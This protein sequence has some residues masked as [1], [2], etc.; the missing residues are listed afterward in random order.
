M[1]TIKFNA[2]DPVYWLSSNGFVFG[3][4]KSVNFRQ[5]KDQTELIYRLTHSGHC[6]IFMGE[7][8]PEHLIFKSYDTMF[9]YYKHA[10]NLKQSCDTSTKGYI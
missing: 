1:T 7:D 10:S 6:D 3:R 4:I 2:G 5:T 8:V 9:E